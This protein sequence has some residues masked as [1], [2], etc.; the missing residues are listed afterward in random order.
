MVYI[1]DVT[2]RDRQNEC[3]LYMAT[4]ACLTKFFTR[5]IQL[6]IVQASTGQQSS[7]FDRRTVWN[8]LSSATSHDN[9]HVRVA[10]QSLS[11]TAMNAI[12]CF[13]GV[14]ASPAE[15]TN[16]TTYYTTCQSVTQHLYVTLH[17]A[18]CNHRRAGYCQVHWVAREFKHVPI[19]RDFR[20]SANRANVAR[21]EHKFSS[22][23]RFPSTDQRKTH[24]VP[25][26]WLCCFYLVW[27]SV[28]LTYVSIFLQLLTARNGHSCAN[29][30]LWNDSV[31]QS[32]YHS[33][34]L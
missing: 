2:L 28:P 15:C 13:C 25:V 24:L 14:P 33:C 12:R 22:P 1:L 20:W 23:H 17:L 29:V 10:A 27:L 16:V 26:P 11:Q 18:R 31:C 6:L 8:S 3:L 7:A 9:R 34:S 21:Y 19:D 4:S 30:Q 5:P 32:V